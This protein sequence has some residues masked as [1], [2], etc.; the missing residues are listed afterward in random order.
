MFRIAFI[1]LFLSYTVMI[2]TSCNKNES[3]RF[4]GIEGISFENYPRVD[5]ST[6]ASVLNMMVGCKLL[7][8]GYRWIEPGAVSEWTLHPKYEELSDHYVNFFWQHIK[9]S[10]THGAFISLIDG[11]SDII[12]THRTISPDEKA[13]AVSKGVTL[14]E[15]PIAS[16][17]FVFIVHADN[18][19]KSLTVNQIQKIYRSEI[20]NWSQVGGKNESMKVFTR[21]RN[22]G[23]EEVFRTV[24]MDGLEPSDFPESAIDRMAQ[25]FHEVMYNV[26]GICYTFKAYKDLQVRV[27]DSQV[28]NL[29][30]N[31]I[32]PDKNTI[33]NK[34]FPFISEVHVAIRSDLDRNSMA[35]KLYEWL[36]SDNAK[37]TLLECGFIPK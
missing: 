25:V 28:R 9:I 10:Q 37:S 18:P 34:T 1:T 36:Q 13:H 15:T 22:S 30:I 5:G 27:P 4:V 31:G 16:D 6:S 35:Y 23:S 19:V 29:A 14:I 21:P 20:T 33:R 2:C 8:V 7:N 17:A 12:V 32:I 3:E 26:D 24:V 11:N